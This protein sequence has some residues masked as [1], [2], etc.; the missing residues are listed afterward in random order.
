MRKILIVWRS[1]HCIG[2]SH[3]VQAIE[4]SPIPKDKITEQLLKELEI[5]LDPSTEEGFD[6]FT[7]P[8]FR[9]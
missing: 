1:I 5:I 6:H 7:H 9:S 8:I 3:M 2:L 4:L